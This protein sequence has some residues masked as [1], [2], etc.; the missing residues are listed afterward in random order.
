[1]FCSASGQ[2]FERGKLRR[3]ALHLV[4][5]ARSALRQVKR[6]WCRPGDVQC[7]AGCPGD[8]VGVD[9]EQVCF[10]IVCRAAILC[11]AVESGDD[12]SLFVQGKR[13]ELLA[14]FEFAK[15]LQSPLG[16]LWRSLSEVLF[17]QFLTGKRGGLQ[18]ERLRGRR[19]FTWDVTGGD[20]AGLQRK[21]RLAVGAVKQIEPSLL[22]CLGHSVDAATVAFHGY[23]SWRGWKITIPNV[24]FHGLK[25][26][27]A[28]AR[29]GVECD[30][31]NGEEIVSDAIES[32]E[33]CCGRSG[34]DIHN[35]TLFIK[36]H[37]GPIIGSA[38]ISPSVFG[39][40]LVTEFAGMRNG[41][42]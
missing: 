10:G 16:D 36:S 17:G 19:D 41:V 12:D 28:L 14:A 21:E 6:L 25:M 5:M 9:I 30:Q 42:K 33:V 24:V 39:P 1:M 3:R 29:F 18:D 35:A 4:S 38:A 2:I 15:A 40:S 23:Q 8:V 37:A 34:W 20:L 26:P 7:H 31:R 32:V 27:Y 11:A 22:A 13:G